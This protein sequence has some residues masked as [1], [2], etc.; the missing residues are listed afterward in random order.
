M[1][2]LINKCWKWLLHYLKWKK[3]II[4]QKLMKFHWYRLHDVKRRYGLNHHTIFKNNY[5]VL[6]YCKVNKLKYSVL[7]E[8]D[9]TSVVEP[10]YYGSRVGGGKTEFTCPPIYIA[11]LEEVEVFGQS[12]CLTLK[13]KIILCDF[14]QIDELNGRRYDLSS[15]SIMKYKNKNA[16][17]LA[18]ID[19]GRTLEKAISLIGCFA[20]N[21]YHFTLEILSRLKYVD[22]IQKYDDYPILVDENALKIEQLKEL[23]NIVNQKKRTV[24][25]VKYG[26]KIHIKELIYISHNIWLPPN[27]F[28]GAVPMPQDFFDFANC[29]YEHQNM[30]IGQ[31]KD[32]SG[33][34]TPK[35]FF[36]KEKL[37]KSALN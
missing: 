1:I 33:K 10:N 20:S 4:R 9:L 12:D 2:S 24:I 32:S 7:Y 14:F 13:D 29:G 35:D 17:T 31:K 36:I 3:I 37:F 5:G 18:Y 19:E 30:C 11:E 22:N 8:G 34:H 15:G 16:V 23:L 27:Y 28:K 26:E 21:Y 25:S 6:E